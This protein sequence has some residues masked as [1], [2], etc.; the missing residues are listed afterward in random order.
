MHIAS[1]SK[2]VRDTIKIIPPNSVND[3]DPILS[4]E[5]SK[6]ETFW[7]GTKGVIWMSCFGIF[8]I[9]S[10]VMGVYLYQM[11]IRPRSSED[12]TSVTSILSPL[13]EFQDTQASDE[14]I[15]TYKIK[16]L[17]GSGAPGEASR[18]KEA[19]EIEGFLAVSVGNA[20]RFDYVNSSVEMK[21]DIPQSVLNSVTNVLSKLYILDEA[22][23]SSEQEEDDIIVIIGRNKKEV[24]E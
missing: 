9:L 11:G 1:Q 8:V 16:I 20:D 14:V 15:P 17:N 2:P 5:N 19:L 4:I 22:K 3:R 12:R 23:V 7:Y 18:V 13:L 6:G 24:T 21:K 10:V